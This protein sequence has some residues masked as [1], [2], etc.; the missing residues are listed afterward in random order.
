MCVKCCDLLLNFSDWE[1]KDSWNKMSSKII[2]FTITYLLTQTNR[3]FMSTKSVQRYIIWTCKDFKPM[4]IS[5]QGGTGST[6]AI[7]TI[8]CRVAVWI[9]YRHMQVIALDWVSSLCIKIKKCVVLY[10]WLE[11]N[12]EILNL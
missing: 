11:V 1:S 10:N 7:T 3:L 5:D 12:R 9:W 6:S 2:W 4:D 8:L